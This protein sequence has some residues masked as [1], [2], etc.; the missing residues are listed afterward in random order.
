MQAQIRKTRDENQEMIVRF[1]SRLPFDPFS[2]K[3]L[4]SLNQVRS[5]AAAKI[6]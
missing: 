2:S 5:D 4:L 1:K 3:S 6:K